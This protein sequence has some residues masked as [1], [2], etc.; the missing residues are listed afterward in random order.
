MPAARQYKPI[1]FA[2]YLAAERDV[3]L[4]S[5]YVDGQVYAMAGAS[6]THNTIAMSLAAAIETG[7][8]DNCRVWQADMKVKGDYEGH[9][10]AYYPDIMAACGENTGDPYARE[11]PVLIVEVLSP[12]TERIDLQEKFT[13]YTRISSLREYVVIAQ[14]M[15]WVRLFRRSHAWRP[16][17]YYAEDSLPLS[18]VGLAIPVQQIYRRVRKEVG[19]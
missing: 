12:A 4:R 19:L 16:A 7:L 18:S 6:E 13:N 10:F 5:E 15:P 2:D 17:S 8:S 11:N 3:S 14:D 1:P 9:Q